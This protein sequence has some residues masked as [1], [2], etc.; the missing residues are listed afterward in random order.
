M[1]DRG[2]RCAT[3]DRLTLGRVL[4]GEAG[5]HVLD[6]GAGYGGRKIEGFAPHQFAMS[7]NLS[8]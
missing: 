7:G 3:W 1:A 5:A 4:L 8:L 6:E 2:W